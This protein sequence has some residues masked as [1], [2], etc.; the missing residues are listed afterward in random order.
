MDGW[1]EIKTFLLGTISK[2][3]CDRFFTELLIVLLE[4]PHHHHHHPPQKKKNPIKHLHGGF[5]VTQT[6]VLRIPNTLFPKKFNFTALL[7][8]Y[9]IIDDIS[10]QMI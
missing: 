5:G 1:I 3:K 7:N 4:N 9:S 8:T 6:S 2:E 10:D